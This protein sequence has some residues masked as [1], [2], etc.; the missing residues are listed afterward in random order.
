MQ[1]HAAGQPVVVGLIGAGKF[2]AM[3]LA[4]ARV[5]PGLH[6]AG[7]ADLDVTRARRQLKD[8][9]WPPEA[10]SAASLNEAV[11]T[12]ALHVSADS[13]MLIADPRVE[14]IIEATGVPTAGIR[15]A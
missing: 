6:I 7:L 9:G 2:G 14:V 15:H 4:Q 10:C 3:F 8:V 5:T 13:E 12:G 11:K 1:R